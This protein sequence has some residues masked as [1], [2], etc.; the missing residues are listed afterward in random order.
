L[1]EIAAAPAA[2]TDVRAVEAATLVVTYPTRRGTRV[3]LIRRPAFMRR[4]PGQIAFPGGMV[5]LT[6]ASPLA[7]AIRETREEVGLRLPAN[8]PARQLL[9]VGTI[10]SGI[11]IQ[12]FWVELPASPR[13]L[14]APDEVDAILRVPLAELRSPGV[15]GWAPHPRR[16]GDVTPAFTWRGEVIWGAT[17]RTVVELLGIEGEA[18]PLP[19]VP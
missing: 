3:I 9:P 8:W 7:A 4:H 2:T 18:P 1:T 14:P 17:A 12:P 15:F 16:P 13:L 10:T 19:P 5:E 11:V 6:D